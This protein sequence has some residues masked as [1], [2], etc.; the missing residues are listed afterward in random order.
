MSYALNTGQWFLLYFPELLGAPDTIGLKQ[1]YRLYCAL[2][3]IC[4]LYVPN[5]VVLIIL[6]SDFKFYIE[7]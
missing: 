5:H 7:L 3:L 4:S 1:T 6:G 2:S